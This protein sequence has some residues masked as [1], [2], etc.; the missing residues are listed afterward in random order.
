MRISTYKKILD[1]CT[2]LCEALEYIQNNGEKSLL[3]LCITS[4]DSI[5][6]CLDS[7]VDSI[8]NN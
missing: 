8:L 2:S 6:R 4:L 7:N 5:A 1:L 3:S